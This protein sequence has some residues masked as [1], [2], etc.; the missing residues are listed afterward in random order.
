MTFEDTN[1]QGP[2]NHG[3]SGAADLARESAA[4]PPLQGSAVPVAQERWERLVSTVTVPESPDE[5]WTALTDP[6]RVAGWLAVCRGQWAVAGRESMLDFEDGEFFW[7]RT[8]DSVAPQAQRRGLLR[9][10]WR[11][12]GVGPATSVTWTVAAAEP[13][14][15]TVTVVEEA[16]NPPSDWR[17]WNGMGWPGILDQLAAHLRTGTEWRWPWRRFGPYLQIPLPVPPYQAWQELTSAAGIQHWLQRS[18]GTL[19]PGEEL[20]LVMG[21]ASGTVR[22]HVTK[23]VD[24]AQEFPSYLPYLE[25]GLRRPT[26]SAALGGRLWI[27]PAGL[28]SSLLQVCHFGWENLDIPEPVTERKLLTGFWTA[29]AGRASMLFLP[30]G[31][32][33]GPHGWSVSGAPRPREATERPPPRETAEHGSGGAMPAMP[34]G[35][36]PSA[37]G[38]FLDRVVSDLGTAMGAVLCSLGV[39]LGLFTALGQGGPATAAELAER[40]GLSERQLLEWLRGLT[41]TGYLTHDRTDGRFALPPAHAAVLAFEDSPFH[42][43]P[44]YELLPPLAAAVDEVAAGFRSGDGVA[45][46]AY[47]DRLF[48]AM[49]RMSATWLDTQLVSQWIPAVEGLLPALERGGEVADIGCGGGRALVRMAR[50]FG[51]CRFTGYELHRPNVLRARE[52]V[53]AANVDDRV[54]VEESDAVGALAARTRTSGDPRPLLLVTMFDVLHDVAAPEELLRTVREALSPDGALL[55]L[56]SLSADDPADNTGPR[57][58]VLYA[59]SSLYCLPTSL[60]DGAPGLGTLGLPPATLRRMATAAG[61][62]RVEQVPTANPFTTLYAL[63]P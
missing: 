62:G 8:L 41:G 59:T 43:G 52:A 54:S 32:P 48:T 63:R 14:G 42:L 29:A 10:L 21:D 12:V 9:L 35:A 34:P 26:W 16:E 22:M 61:F 13:G 40:T 19:A 2:R 11:W 23:V 51:N 6:D 1:P 39:R 3:P 24:A 49:E 44:G 4:F 55:V 25:F 57:S 53:G 18:S 50:A 27:E 31:P 37:V 58:T 7:C 60:A 46:S 36:D 30:Q 47:A 15:T 28:E 17:S 38:E 5:V 56:E 20:T 33:A 45:R